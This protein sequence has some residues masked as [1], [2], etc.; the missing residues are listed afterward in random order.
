MKHFLLN[1]SIIILFF[2]MLIF[3]EA[4]FSGACNGLLLWFHTVLPTLL[5]FLILSN[6]LLNTS[7]IQ[8]LV[9]IISPI[10]CKI[11]RTS[12]YGS[13]AILCGFLCGYPI[14]GK[15]ASDLQISKKISR[16]ESAYLLSFCNNTSPMF[17]ISYVV[18]Q[19]F[20]QKSLILPSLTILMLSP[21]LCSFIFR[22]FYL[23]QQHTFTK[24][25]VNQST[26]TESNLID[27]CIMNSFE[28]VT[29]IGG[30]IIMFSVFIEI[31]MTI[32]LPDVLF[33][34]LVLCTLEITTGISLIADT[35]LPFK[36]MYVFILALTSFGG[37]CSIA[38]T[39]SIIKDSHLSIFHY[40]IEKLATA[41][42]TSL[43]AYIYIQFY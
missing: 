3:P 19:N 29:K 22:Q 40:I 2:S 10:L 8:L 38:Q 39:Q 33:I 28:T 16:N 14:G 12:S 25:S 42:V 1:I 37:W 4:V 32:N 35:G 21:I 20:N 30:Y 13:F 36:T 43:L 24:C 18:N 17:V 31:F 7:A 11:F 15:I 5:P 26:N 9:H 23:F 41:S 6:L 34:K 27:Y